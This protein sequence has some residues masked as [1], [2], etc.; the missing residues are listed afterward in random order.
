[1]PWINP[2]W[3]SRQLS[4]MRLPTSATTAVASTRATWFARS[5]LTALI[6]FAISALVPGYAHFKL[7]LNVRIFHVEHLTDG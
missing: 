7:N 2:S 3:V 4:P 5:T 1:M 6:L